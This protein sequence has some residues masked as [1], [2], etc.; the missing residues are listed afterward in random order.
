MIRV[1]ILS[2]MLAFLSVDMW[3][4]H[5]DVRVGMVVAHRGSVS[6][7]NRTALLEGAEISE[8]DIITVG[9]KSFV[10]IQFEDGSKLT[11][12]PNSEI[13]VTK[14]TMEGAEIELVSG[15]LRLI[16]GLI[17]K[18][19]PDQ[20]KIRTPIALMG[21]RGTEFSIIYIEGE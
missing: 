9:E 18:E 2:I 21:V 13:I 11:I 8:G 4:D 12:R 7:Q 14:Y 19:N 17:A 16:T 3:A 20:Y 10:V 5:T 6:D 15:G 1:F